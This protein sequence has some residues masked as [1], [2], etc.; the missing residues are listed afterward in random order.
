MVHNVRV[1]VRVLGPLIVEGQG[2]AAVG[3]RK[4]RTLLT[5]LATAGG[6]PVPVD[7]LVDL[8]WEDRPPTKPADQV[9]VLA[10][11][12]R[13]A[14]GAE[15]IKRTDAGYALHADWVDA[16]EFGGRCQ[17]AAARLAAG[18]LG[19]A[20]AAAASALELIRGPLAADEAALWFD[21]RRR[22]V[23][24]VVARARTILAQA[25]IATGDP[26]AA[27][28]AAGDALADDPYDEAALRILMR[29]HVAL[30]RPASALAAYA[31]VR[32]RLGEDLG[33]D[34][35]PETEALHTSIL[36]GEIEHPA[37]SAAPG[38]RVLFGRDAELDR[39]QQLLADVAGGM[40][41]GVVI[42]GEAGIGK[43]ALTA[44]FLDRARDQSLILYGRCDEMGRDL[45]LQPIIDGLEPHVR[46]L[47]DDAMADLLAADAASVAPLLGR[48]SVPPD[49]L[50][51]TV[52]DREIGRGVL[53]RGVL[54]VI[55][56]LAAGGP[57]IVVVEDTHLAGASTMTWLQMALRRGQKLLVVT[58]R[59]PD[60]KTDLAGVTHIDLG[61]LEVAAVAMWLGEQR[62]AELVERSGGNPLFLA[63]LAAQEGDDLPPSI[64]DLVAARVDALGPAA[65]TLRAAAV[66]GSAIDLDQIA[67]VLA[68][69]VS[70]L[71]DHLEHGV[72]S[73]LLVDDAS[74]LRFRH[75]LVRDALEVSTSVPRRAF[76]HREAA[77]V[78][79]SRAAADPM[80]VAWHAQ[81]AG[82]VEMAARALVRAASVA[83]ARFD[84]DEAVRLLDK[85]I[86]LHDDTD[87]RLARARARMAAW[88][89][90]GA[91]IDAERAIA[92]GGGGPAFELAGWV[93]Y[94]GR[95]HVDT[96][97]FAEEGMARS[98]DTAVR[99]SCLSLAG[100][101][102]H[103]LGDLDAAEGHLRE[104]VAIAPPAVRPVAQIWL[105]GL[106][107]HRGDDLEALELTSRA[108]LGFDQ[109]THPFAPAHALFARAQA[110]GHRGDVVGALEVLDALDALVASEGD[111]L[112]RFDAMS[113][114]CR[115]WV[116]RNV[117]ELDAACQCN[118]VA[119]ALPSDEPPYA[120]PRFAGH[121][122]L[123]DHELFTG[124][125]EA[126]EQ[127]FDGIAEIESWFGSMHWRHKTR[128]RLQRA[129]LALARH[130]S[131]LALAIAGEVEA[132]CR[133]R[134]VR[135]YE[136]LAS[137]V[138]A[139]AGADTE[140]AAFVRI[141]DE[142]ERRAALEVWWLTA[143]L[144]AHLD[145]A[146][147]WLDAQRR[148]DTLAMA[149][150][151]Y[152]ASLRAYA[153]ERFSSLR[154]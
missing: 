27:G 36:L 71:L 144:A 52:S 59:R 95:A 73:R 10:S 149:A 31:E 78:L 19:A 6:D 141:L 74:G 153:A 23:E 49:A 113:K 17:E 66:L 37:A 111:Q 68:L 42:E 86:N 57:A 92:L 101:T 122:D 62:A 18:Q 81:R 63:E 146:V 43:S 29:A 117:G 103:T 8:L 148:V 24:P 12:L 1:R 9:S 35:S 30:G 65:A 61:P 119:A 79:A 129:R 151:P 3:S 135:R 72:R 137:L 38:G 104:A 41:R 50:V 22:A 102:R 82:D 90:A 53:Y 64:R 91:R 45:P 11:R 120:E 138:A 60:G 80:E 97:R 83:S 2:L 121:L 4:A 98:D 75:E 5:A 128:Y 134:S 99:A 44:A 150:G 131:P 55:E 106:R 118:E 16:V 34:P 96:L 67:S 25:A 88:D 21:D 40:A 133:E 58:T 54:T 147:L 94:Y 125:V 124:D 130:N 109:V 154:A 139:R 100:R 46:A 77:A 108:A 20:R 13:K 116:L 112:R 132:D 93:A 15:R 14:F 76:L 56:R 84:L 142:L 87:A 140:R 115:A 127:R 48:S 26:I 123:V 126:A 85:A 28:A 69:P 70:G 143:E 47:P 105:A 33:V 110:F 145:D 107:T 39:L 114:N 32:S 136:L 89:I 51:T 7:E 152:A